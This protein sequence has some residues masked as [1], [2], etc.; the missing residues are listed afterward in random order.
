M[1]QFT[2]N[3]GPVENEEDPTGLA[4]SDPGAKLDKGKVDYTLVPPSLFRTLAQAFEDED[5]KLGFS[6]IP[7]KGLVYYARLFAIGAKKYSPNG[8]KEVEDGEK[9]YLK[10]LMRHVEKVREGEWVDADTG[11]PHMVCV[12]WNAF[13]VLW[14]RE[15]V[16]TTK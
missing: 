13:A 9:R 15:N 1:G 7:F 4:A 8:W 5:T 6:L 10:A 12:A 2:V 14:F 16:T 11:L 3:K